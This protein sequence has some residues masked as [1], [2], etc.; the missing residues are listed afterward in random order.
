ML[1]PMIGCV[2][3]CGR[4]CATVCGRACATVCSRACARVGKSI[5]SNTNNEQICTHDIPIYS[6]EIDRLSIE[7]YCV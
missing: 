3:L 1:G 2:P 4:A 5:I 7:K 6:I